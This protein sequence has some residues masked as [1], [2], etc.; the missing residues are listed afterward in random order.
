MAGCSNKETYPVGTD[1]TVEKKDGANV[2]GKLVEVKPEQIVLEARDGAKTEVREVPDRFRKADDCGSG[3]AA[4]GGSETFR[5]GRE[6][7]GR[8]RRERTAAGCSG[9]TARSSA[10]RYREGCYGASSETSG[11]PGGHPAV[12]DDA[13]GD[14]RNVAGV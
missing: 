2:A 6:S 1:V 10:R 13:L 5:G 12:R 14:A 4:R 8:K 11:I 9:T 7:A 3:T